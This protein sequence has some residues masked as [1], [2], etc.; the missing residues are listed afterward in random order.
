M[1]MLYPGVVT[2]RVDDLKIYNGKESIHLPG[3]VFIRRSGQQGARVL[4][5]GVL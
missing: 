4:V 3:F 5:G 2:S 1:F